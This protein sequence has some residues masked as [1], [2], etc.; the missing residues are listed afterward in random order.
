M[1]HA[2]PLALAVALALGP[3]AVPLGADG[4]TSVVQPTPPITSAAFPLEST[5]ATP[6]FGDGLIPNP[7]DPLG[8]APVNPVGCAVEFAASDTVGAAQ[9]NAWIAAH[10]DSISAPTMVCLAGTFTAPIDVWAK[11]SPALLDL[12]AAPGQSATID[13]GLVTAGEADPNE[14]E[15][16]TGAVSVIDSR[17]VE[18]EGLT[19]TGAHAAGAAV[20]PAGIL[21]EA[22]SDVTSTAAA[23]PHRSACFAAGGCGSIFILDD[24]VTDIVNTADEAP[25]TRSSC[26]NPNVGAYGIAVLDAGPD[27]GPGLQHVV[28][29]GDTVSGTRT[30]QSETVTVNGNVTDFLVADNVV[31]DADN[32][33]IVTIGWELDHGQAHHGLITGNLVYDVD[34]WS[35]VSYGHWTGTACVAQPENAAGIYT[36]GAA[37]VWISDNQ[38]EDT[39]QG[40][41]M[42]VETPHETTGHLLV[43]G[44]TVLDEPGTSKA[45]PSEGPEPPGVTGTSSVAGHDVYAFFVDAYGAGSSISDVYAADNDFTNLSQHFLRPDWGMPVVDLAGRYSHVMLWA[46]TVTGGGAAD[47]LNPLLELD[48]LPAGP[49]VID[50]EDYRGLTTSTSS[51]N[52]NFALP[53]RSF[54]SLSAW[55]AHNGH[56]FDAHSGVE[57]EGAG[58]VA[59]IV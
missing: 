35:N 47:R 15:L 7:A 55:V 12:T 32:I 6:T 10:Q 33:G 20:T 46:N 22:R 41:N 49:T 42:D 45:D 57:S 8:P 17:D 54:L 38:V 37:Y 29:E 28:I 39:D 53:S 16:D 23:V 43:T 27:T 19:V 50:C 9:V 11:T 4:S 26:G 36:D 14:Y 3:R 40:I 30:G 2:G 52:G 58:C 51:V 44:N 34:T 56:R 25:A 13:P 59:A 1:R 24:T 31:D 5:R 18:V 48:S 21:V